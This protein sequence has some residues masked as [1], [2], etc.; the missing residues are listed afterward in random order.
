MAAAVVV[1]AV[2][3][4][5]SCSSDRDGIL[6]VYNWSS[7]I[8]EGVIDDFEAWY[9]EVTGKDIHVIYQTFDIN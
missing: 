8:G 4:F 6:K 1:A 2:M 9:K 3:L 5:T 7:Y